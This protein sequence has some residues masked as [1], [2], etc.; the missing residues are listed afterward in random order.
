MTR[1]EHSELWSWKV[2]LLIKS[3]SQGQTVIDSSGEGNSAKS[4]E[5]A[6]IRL[7]ICVLEARNLQINQC[8]DLVAAA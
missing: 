2:T 4:Q 1:P 6:R 5:H 8:W 3:D 7:V